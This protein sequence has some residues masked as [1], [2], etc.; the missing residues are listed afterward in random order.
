M[1][2]L[3]EYGDMVGMI[4]G[5][6]LLAASS[7]VPPQQGG[8]IFFVIGMVFLVA[9]QPITGKFFELA[10]LKKTAIVQQTETDPNLFKYEKN[11]LTMVYG[12]EDPTTRKISQTG[13]EFGFG[14]W[15]STFRMDSPFETHPRY[16]PITKVAYIHD[17]PLGLMFRLD[18]RG[19]FNYFGQWIKGHMHPIWV[20]EVVDPRIPVPRIGSGDHLGAPR[21]SPRYKIIMST[22]LFDVRTGRMSMKELQQMIAKMEQYAD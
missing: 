3:E 9:G 17:L 6:L 7:Q 21:V 20:K 14:I 8:Q 18:E 10:A 4:P 22:G 1:D 13:G 2:F 12:K 16:G 15:E 19:R 5:F 11:R